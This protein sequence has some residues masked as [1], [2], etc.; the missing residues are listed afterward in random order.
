MKIAFLFPGQGS[1]KP[2]LL[3]EL[4][5]CEAVDKVLETAS[6]TLDV[7]AYNL[8]LEESLSSTKNVQLSLLIAGIAAYKAFEAEGVKPHFVA[9]HSVGAFS[10]AVATGAIAFK[11][12]LRMVSLRGEL[13]ERAY[14]DGYG[15]GVVLGME[16]RRLQRLVD[17]Y[18]DNDNPVFI[19][20]QNA[21]D[22]VTISGSLPSIQ[23]VLEDARQE[24]ARCASLLN[25]NI[26][27]HCPLLQSVS[28]SLAEALQGISF[29]RPKIPYIGNRR[30][31]VLYDPDEI[32][33]DLAESVSTPVQWHDAST[34]LYEKGVRLFIEMPPG[35][36]LADL[37][38]KA[39]P[40]AR[41]FSV[42]GNGFDDC[43]YIATQ[44]QVN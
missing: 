8:H 5:S 32:K 21:P 11:D 31:R 34:V 1:Q 18:S 14:P 19:A 7:N 33:L 17:F 16:T 26:P 30:A 38:E 4:P 29:S 44:E 23:R 6:A 42:T 12:A 20:N 10:A 15:M 40:D 41:I 39:F 27:S 24:G 28:K 36:V 9:G 3:H 22:Q 2:G 13:M 37:A 25:V 43:A 35:T